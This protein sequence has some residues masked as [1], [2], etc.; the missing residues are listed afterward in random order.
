M[1]RTPRTVDQIVEQQVARWQLERARRREEARPHPVI[2]VSRQYGARGAAVAHA[3]A[4]RLGYSYW[5]REIVEEIARHAQVSELLVRNFDEHHRASIVETV[6]SMTVGGR[7][8]SSEYFRELALV[9]HGIAQHGDAVIV[10]RGAGFLVPTAFRVRVVAPVDDRVRGLSERRGIS[11][12]EARTQVADTDADRAAFVHDHYGRVVDDP[13]AYD[14]YVNTASFGVDG[15]ADI[16]V[17][18]FRRSHA[19]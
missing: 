7:L 2:T 15:A 9:V 11:A 10:G 19:T 4:E 12:S 14:L 6:R 17:A 3:V 5:N 13:A 16:V 8:S 18:A 1:E